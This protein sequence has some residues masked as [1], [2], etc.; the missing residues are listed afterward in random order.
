MY[1][2]SNAETAVE[3]QQATASADPIAITRDELKVRLGRG[4]DF[5][6]VETLPPEQFRDGHLPGAMNMPPDQVATLAPKL[7]PD[8]QTEVITYCASRTCHASA[9]AARELIKLGYT[10]VRHYAGGKA[11]W[12]FAGLPVERAK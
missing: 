4:G 11:D 12:R 6:L 8:K 9:D 2:K 7:L 1:G 5:K 10:N 3:A